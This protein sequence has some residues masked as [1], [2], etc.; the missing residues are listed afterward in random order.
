MSC[1]TKVRR[2]LGQLILLNGAELTK[3]SQWRQ[4]NSAEPT[5]KQQRTLLQKQ[6]GLEMTLEGAAQSRIWCSKIG[7]TD[8]CWVSVTAVVLIDAVRTGTSHTSCFMLAGMFDDVCFYVN[9]FVK[10]NRRWWHW[11]L[12]WRRRLQN[13]WNLDNTAYESHGWKKLQPENDVVM[14][15]KMPVLESVFEVQHRSHRVSRSS[16]ICVVRI[17][18]IFI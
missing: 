5:G 9:I 17:L 1:G 3:Q 12:R 11:W 10:I 6:V 8:I 15:Y 16:T 4:T 13:E 14:V 18:C 7:C 2:P